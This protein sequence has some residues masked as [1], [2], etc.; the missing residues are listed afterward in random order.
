MS[1]AEYAA[2]VV[3]DWPPLTP[4][5]VEAAARILATVETEAAAA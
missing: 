4:E 1:P 5:Q 2:V 3:A